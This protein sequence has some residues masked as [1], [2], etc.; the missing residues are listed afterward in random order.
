MVA[1]TEEL[2]DDVYGTLERY[3]VRSRRGCSSGRH[4][5]RATTP[6]LIERRNAAVGR[7]RDHCAKSVP[8]LSASWSLD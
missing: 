8:S 3:G 5:S 1:R 2:G 6:S 7:G 4:R